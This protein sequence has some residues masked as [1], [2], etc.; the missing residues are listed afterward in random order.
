M[1]IWR[2]KKKNGWKRSLL[3]M[4]A[5]F[6]FVFTKITALG[7]E[8]TPGMIS[9]NGDF[10]IWY[11]S[12]MLPTLI[13][14]IYAAGQSDILARITFV[15]YYDT[16]T[17]L[18]DLETILQ[19]P[20]DPLYPDLIFLEPDYAAKI[21]ETEAFL[22][23]EDLGITEMD[24]SNMFPYTIDNGTDAQGE[25]RTFYC[26]VS[27]GAYQ[28]RADLA[29]AYLG[30]S[31]SAELY[32]RYFCDWK[33]M[34]AAAR[35]VYMES[36]GMVALIPGYGE[37]YGGLAMPRQDFSWVDENNM[38]ADAAQI[39]QMMRLSRGFERYSLGTKQWSI[40]WMDA[41]SGDGV[42]TPAA[43]AYA[44]SPW[45]TGF[46]LTDSWLNNT[47]IVQGPADFQWGGNGFAATAGCSDV[48]FAAD[49]IRTL[50]CD[51]D[52]MTEMA[53]GGE[54][55]NNREALVRGGALGYGKCAYLCNQSQ[56]LFQVYRPLAEDTS[57]NHLTAYDS[58]IREMYHYSLEQYI[59]QGGGMEE[60][61]ELG[62][63]LR[64]A[65][66]EMIASKTNNF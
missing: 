48:S 22:S 26:V 52:A 47:V 44:G 63:E 23:A 21:M 35:K 41:M 38:P 61:I 58:E 37:L 59:T 56:D 46:C 62:E 5:V 27:P 28:V 66:E 16:D 57:G 14:D 8:L 3:A 25:I 29:E 10:V 20:E 45:F 15:A 60:S 18:T 7:A 39:A 9:G 32:D 43:I 11:R 13:T 24:M 65:L 2:H 55:V 50:C 4:L 30:T 33:K 6:L 31:N 53:A 19:Y 42:Q 40:E 54:F 34:M 49:I 36:G 51:V 17:F 1:K 12:S 64:D